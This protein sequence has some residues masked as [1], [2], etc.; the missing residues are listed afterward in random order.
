WCTQCRTWGRCHHCRR[1]R[2]RR[3]AAV[4]GSGEDESLLPP[5]VRKTSLRSRIDTFPT[6]RAAA[7][8][9]ATPLP[10]PPAPDS[11]ARSPARPARRSSGSVPG[12]DLDLTAPSGIRCARAVT[13]QAGLIRV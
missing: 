11:S 13:R 10:L 5:A 1:A 6:S 3:I 9:L 7:T 4:A 12:E 8:A 2:G